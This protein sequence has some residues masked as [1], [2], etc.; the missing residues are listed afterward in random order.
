MAYTPGQAY[1]LPYRLIRRFG[2]QPIMDAD[3]T[4]GIVRDMPLSSIPAGGVYDAT[5]LL[6]DQVG[7]ARKRGG[8]SY[9]SNA[10]GGTTTGVP[11][12]AVP[13]YPTG[14][15][16]VGLGANGHLYDATGGSV[17]DAG[18]FPFV[19]VD[20]PVLVIDKLIVMPP[21]AVFVE[22]PVGDLVGVGDRV[23]GSVRQHPD[24]LVCGGSLVAA[25][26]GWRRSEE[27]G[28]VR[29]CP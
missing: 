14:Q 18:A 10:L 21:A 22:R 28:V 27:P 16:I 8:S 20:N 23:R 5:D 13:D 11:M 29:A 12:V 25:G 24:R 15:K 9:Q 19:P 6:L 17:V 7:V 26:G 2:W 3:F 1:S 4:L